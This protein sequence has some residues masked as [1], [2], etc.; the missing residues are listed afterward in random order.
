MSRSVDIALCG[1]SADLGS[2][3]ES[4]EEQ[5]TDLEIQLEANKV[6]M[7]HVQVQCQK[8]GKLVTC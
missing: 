6:K 7:Q 8:S 2:V 1:R 4:K 3:L 5:I